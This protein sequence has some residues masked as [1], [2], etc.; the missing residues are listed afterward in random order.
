[1]A[2]GA[3]GIARDTSSLRAAATQTQ[4]SSVAGWTTSMRPPP[5][6]VTHSPPMYKRSGYLTGTAYALSTAIG[7]AFSYRRN[8]LS[9]E[10]VKDPTRDVPGGSSVK[11]DVPHGVDRVV[12]VHSAN[13]FRS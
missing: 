3:A 9:R 7:W 5:P 2:G 10:P 8:L 1:M 12:S 11:A 13:T 6:G 4:A